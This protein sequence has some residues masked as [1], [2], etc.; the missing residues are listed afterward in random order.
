VISRY[1]KVYFPYVTLFEEGICDLLAAYIL[2]NNSIVPTS[3]VTNI[4]VYNRSLKP[5]TSLWYAYWAYCRAVV[6]LALK[7]G[8]EV[9]IELVKSGRE[10]IRKFPIQSAVSINESPRAESDLKDLA[11]A[12]LKADALYNV[13][14]VLWAEQSKI[15]S[16]QGEKKW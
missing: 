5:Q 9:I 10:N 16:K 13:K 1:S 7:N 3:A 6:N 4:F 15:P 2:Y 11:C 12:F 14:D 8:F